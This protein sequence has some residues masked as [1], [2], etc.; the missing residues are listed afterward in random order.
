[1]LKVMRMLLAVVPILIGSAAVRA[2]EPA[3]IHDNLQLSPEVRMLLQE[4]MREIAGA[5]Q[6]IV[7]SLAAGDWASIRQ[8]SEQISAS[9]VM[10]QK[11][12]EAQK[13]ELED[14]LPERFKHMDMAFHARAA[15][16][17]MAAESG[18]PER[19]AYEFGRLLESCS[20]CHA[21]FAKSRFPGFLSR[22]PEA[23]RH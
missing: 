5:S 18:D 7:I 4:E 20:T 17:G 14:R 10:A 3:V 23:H 8:R 12:T 6:A 1:M 21:A 19:V 13:Q 16:L 2:Q 15:K 11:L 9:Y 22:A